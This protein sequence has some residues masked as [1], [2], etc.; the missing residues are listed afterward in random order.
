MRCLWSRWLFIII[1]IIH[2]CYHHDKYDVDDKVEE[3]AAQEA[4]P[5]DLQLAYV[6]LSGAILFD[7]MLAIM[8][9]MMIMMIMIMI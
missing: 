5:A 7:H 3:P 2:H 9:M 6:S 1:T 4:E 8:I